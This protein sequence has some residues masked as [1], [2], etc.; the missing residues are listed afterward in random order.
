V[1]SVPCDIEPGHQ[2]I[3]TSKRKL[4][5]RLGEHKKSLEADLQGI[6]PNMTN[7]NGIPYHYATTGHNFLFDQTKIL[8]RETHFLKRKI[9]EGIHIAHNKSS[10]INTIAGRKIDNCWTPILAELFA[11]NPH[12][13]S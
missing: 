3:G 11:D 5:I 10:C 7:D 13:S 2:Y 6:T 4:H 12:D 1:Y 8:E 9:L